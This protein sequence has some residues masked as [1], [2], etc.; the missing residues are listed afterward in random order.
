MHL[1]RVLNYNYG[2]KDCIL[3]SVGRIFIF[4]WFYIPFFSCKPN[5]RFH[6]VQNTRGHAKLFRTCKLTQILEEISFGDGIKFFFFTVWSI[7]Y[8]TYI[9]FK[10]LKKFLKNFAVSVQFLLECITGTLNYPGDPFIT[11]LLMMLSFFVKTAIENKAAQKS[12][13]NISRL[14]FDFKTIEY[15]SHGTSLTVLFAFT[16]YL[17]VYFE[18]FI[19]FT[20]T[21]CVF[22]FSFSVMRNGTKTK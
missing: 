4:S 15:F 6:F 14:F 19:F 17:V 9:L 8:I 7:T 20:F 18:Y 1:L 21:R 5:R 11:I 16:I 13:S 2:L 10:L 12:L 3:C 22:S